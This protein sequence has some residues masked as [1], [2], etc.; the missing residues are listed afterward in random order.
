MLS[1]H[2]YNQ[3]DSR[4][5][6]TKQKEHIKADGQELSS[7][8]IAALQDKKAQDVVEMD[9]TSVGVSLFD[10]FIICT[11]TS[12]THA[13]A[14]TDSVYRMVKEKTGIIPNHIEGTINAQWILMDY[15]DTVVHI[16]LAE[17]REYYAL[18]RLWADAAKKEY[19]GQ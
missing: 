19:A 18:E 8:I 17:T 9:L 6:M 15:F 10:K 1:L 4:Y 16:F 5:Y 3:I 13:D 7:C 2:F 11:A 14:L 12:N